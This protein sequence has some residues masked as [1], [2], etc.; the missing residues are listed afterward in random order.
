M[1]NGKTKESVYNTNKTKGGV[2]FTSH[3]LNSMPMNGAEIWTEY[4]TRITKYQ[5]FTGL[6]EGHEK[7]INILFEAK[8]CKTLVVHF[9]I[10]NIYGG[11]LKQKIEFIFR[12]EG[13]KSAR[14]GPNCKAVI[15]KM[16]DDE[17]YITIDI[18][19]NLTS[20]GENKSTV[21]VHVHARQPSPRSLPIFTYR[22][23]LLYKNQRME[24]SIMSI[25]VDS[26]TCTFTDDHTAE[27]NIK[28][29]RG[30]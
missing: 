30:S 12:L 9:P 19:S 18:N 5:D 27:K 23:V 6:Y 17:D 22:F 1:G 13:D 4:T 16:K 25:D 28:K 14:S 24:N 21:I 3:Q 2:V 29:Q 20:K 26:I 10:P 8:N 11:S 15:C 7:G